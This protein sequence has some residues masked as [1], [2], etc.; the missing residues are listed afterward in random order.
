M[1]FT[2]YTYKTE[3]QLKRLSKDL[4][5]GFQFC[6]GFCSQKRKTLCESDKWCREIWTS[7]G[8]TKG[9]RAFRRCRPITVTME[10][11]EKK[12]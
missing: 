3:K 6:P 4:I 12:E 5:L 9:Y 11:R 10:F 2:A 8:K 7:D 1:T